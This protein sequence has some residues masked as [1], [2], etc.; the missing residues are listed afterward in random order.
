MKYESQILA[1]FAR[2]GFTPRSNQIS[3]INDVVSAFIDA[4]KKNVILNAPTGTGKSI[5]G[6]VTA[7]VISDV[8]GRAGKEGTHSSISITAT[9]I[10]NKQYRETFGNMKNHEFLMIKGA[11]NYKCKAL[12]NEQIFE[13]AESCIQQT[14]K[15][16]GKTDK[17]IG[18][19]YAAN[20][21]YRNATRHVSTNY[22]YYF[23]DQ[24][25]SQKG[26]ESRDIIIWDEAHLLNEIF[27]DFNEISFSEKTL[28]AMADDQT[29][30]LAFEDHDTSDLQVVMKD[31]KAGKIDQRNYRDYLIR[32]KKLYMTFIKAFASEAEF[33][34]DGKNISNY[35]KFLKLKKKYV[36]KYQKID[37]LEK[38]DYDHV[39]E[40][41]EAEVVASIKPIFVNTI[42]PS[43]LNSTYNLFM[44]ATITPVLFEETIGLN[45][46]ETA[47]IKVDPI[48]PKE[49]KKVVFY[50]T[51]SLNFNSLR[52]SDTI[53]ELTSNINKIIS[54]HVK[55]GENGIILTPSFALQE[56][57][58][59]VVSDSSFQ[60]YIQNK[61]DKLEEVV[62]K[63]KAHKGSKPAVLISPSLFEGVDLPGDLSRFQVLVKAP[64]Q[65]L[66]DKRVKYIMDNHKKIYELYTLMKIIQG[67]GRSIRS[68]DD[69]ATTYV[70]DYNAEKLFNGNL[71]I[72]KDEFNCTK[73]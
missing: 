54:R 49:S 10:L 19:E 38:Y 28:K 59:K 39:F 23:I 1:A 2:I 68:M 30:A 70:L 57:I 71:N 21:S 11:N 63:F 48:F 22:A 13:S 45:S 14:L 52:S 15:V 64:Y 6:I 33:Y 17:C 20:K 35:I 61:G 32:V 40:F 46:N 58:V 12:S 60:F 69:Y 56:T 42:F 7:E 72:W 4:G 37:D 73:V 50:K 34:L 44:S 47:F 16:M 27:A 26:L 66:S 9:N 65:S 25:Y 24:M 51:K 62:N 36:Q 3:V 29:K 5:I 31:L 8:I 67:A 53:E 41:K 43:L 18:C 55:K